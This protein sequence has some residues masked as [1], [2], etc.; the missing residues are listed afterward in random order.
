MWECPSNFAASVQYGRGEALDQSLAPL[1]PVQKKSFA[2]TTDAGPTKASVTKVFY[3]YRAELTGLTPGAAYSYTVEAA[4]AR[5][6]PQQFRTL[7]PRAI[8]TRFIVYGDSRSNPVAH[9]A[10][11]RQFLAHEPE[12]IL[13]T[14]DL[15]AR[16]EDYNLWSREFFGPAGEVIRRVPIFPVIGNHEH[17]GTNYLAYFA[18]PGNELWYSFDSGPVHVLALDFRREKNR[19]AQ[20]QFARKDLLTSPAPWKIVVLHTPVYNLGGHASNWGHQEYLPLF[21]KAKVDLVL[22]GHSHLYERFRPLAPRAKNPAW[23]ITHITTGGGGA[24]LHPAFAHPAVVTSATT[25][26]FMVFEATKESLHA[27]AIETGGSLLDDFELRKVEGHYSGEFLAGYYPQESLDLFFEFSPALLPRVT[28]V[29]GPQAPVAT[30]FSVPPR[31]KGLSLGEMELAL[32]PASA[33]AYEFLNGPLRVVWPA[34][35][36]T[37]VVWAQV[38]ARP[39]QLIST[40]RSGELSP[41]LTFQAEVKTKEGETLVLGPKARLSRAAQEAW[42]K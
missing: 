22:T 20:Y 6:N 34:R 2:N 32:T 35:D 40:N 30:M 7:D 15:V 38:Q 17:D 21:L 4:G 9:Q 3:L 8:R 24:N 5:T 25:N 13:H 36:Y 16:G 41:P 29:P 14:G 31:R 11:T 28:G 27:R 10:L 23:A 19:D 33:K 26:H 42:G 18:L 1:I 37:N 12:F 39:G